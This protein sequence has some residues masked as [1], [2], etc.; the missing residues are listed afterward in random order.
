MPARMAMI[1]MTTRSSIKV[2]ASRPIPFT[3]EPGDVAAG[4]MLEHWH[5]PGGYGSKKL[6][7]QLLDHPAARHQ[8]V[9]APEDIVDVGLRTD[10]E[11]VVQ[12]SNDV[13][14]RNRPLVR[15]RAG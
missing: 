3:L 12:R 4:N 8:R 14:R 11:Q 6:T 7:D 13:A 9:R 2:K 15:R 5:G 1:A 10:S